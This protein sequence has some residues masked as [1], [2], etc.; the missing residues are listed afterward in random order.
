VLPPGVELVD[1][2]D[3]L[4]A[5]GIDLCVVAAPTQ[6]HEELGLQLCAAEVPA[7]IE[8]PL[9]V[10]SAAARR[11]VDAFRRAG[12]LM[13]VGHIERYNPALIEL[14]RRLENGELGAI[15]QISTR[16][17]G[18][19]PVRIRDV[20]VAKD[21]ATH[22]LDLA[23]WIGTSPYASISARTASKLGSPYEDL[24]AATGALGDGTITNHLINWLTPVK[25]RTIA[26]TGERGVFIADTLSADLTFCAN[27]EIPVEW[28]VIGEFRGVSEGDVIRYALRKPEP[29]LTELSS[30][31][32]AVLGEPA[33]LVT[34]EDGLAAVELAEA[35]L[36]S[37]AD[38][39]RT[40]EL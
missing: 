21:L 7:L 16:R 6:L 4:L 39:G 30:F 37:A 25:D 15:F 1:D 34:M 14:R 29:L 24:L 32:D 17:Q 28:S 11:L 22:D 9:A 26:V 3:Q 5:F 10:D 27:G 33:R 20:G 18:P 35:C 31:R 19:F 36:R 38:G 40:V 23:A 2:L 12:V 13:S 8:K